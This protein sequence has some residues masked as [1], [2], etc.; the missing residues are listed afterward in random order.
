MMLAAFHG[1]VAAVKVLQEVG[2]VD[3]YELVVSR[4]LHPRISPCWLVLLIVFLWTLGWKVCYG[5]CYIFSSG[6][7]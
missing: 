1:H 6:N 4:I 7:G 5:H 3:I 2:C